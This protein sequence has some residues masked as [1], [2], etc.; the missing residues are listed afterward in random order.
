MQVG[1]FVLVFGSGLLVAQLV[2]GCHSEPLSGGDAAGGAPDGGAPGFVAENG[3]FCPDLASDWS[4]L[5]GETCEA[6]PSELG[7]YK[8]WDCQSEEKHYADE[9]LYCFGTWF[10][11]SETGSCATSSVKLGADG[12][13]TTTWEEADG[14][15]CSEEGA[16][17]LR[18][19]GGCP[20]DGYYYDEYLDCWNQRWRWGFD[21]GDC[22]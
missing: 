1:Q 19:E 15:P 11:S 16:Q 3:A 20:A 5:D 4:K 13:P 14:V 10:W 6:G 12:C 21:E 18:Q 17:C 2:S 8:V 9:Y 7:C 22:G